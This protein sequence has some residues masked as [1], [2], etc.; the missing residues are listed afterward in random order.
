[1]KKISA[2]FLCFICIVS[3]SGCRKKEQSPDFFKTNLPFICDVQ[4]KY[5]TF[6]ASGCLAYRN[7]AGATLEILSPQE[8]SG[9]IFEYS[10]EQINASYKGISFSLNDSAATPAAKLIFSA[11]STASHKAAMTDGE[12]LFLTGKT[13]S[14]S[15]ELYFDN[16]S[17]EIEALYCPSLD[18]EVGFKNFEFI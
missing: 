6:S 12:K 10:G 3:L 18:L 7:A 14:T 9:I 8:I 1:M 5:D 4:I 2:I 15:W 11:L 13:D 17:G 16:K